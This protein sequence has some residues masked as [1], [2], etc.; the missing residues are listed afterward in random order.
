MYAEER[1]FAYNKQLKPE[2]FSFGNLVAV[3]S[4]ALLEGMDFFATPSVG[5]IID[6]PYNLDVDC[7]NDLNLAEA[8]LQAG[9]V[10][11]DNVNN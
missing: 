5:N 3:R 8:I 4:T 7:F 10:R 2:V 11:L 6:W 9:L 1:H